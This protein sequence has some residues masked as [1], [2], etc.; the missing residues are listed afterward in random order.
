MLIMRDSKV[1]IEAKYQHTSFLN[2]G[3][4]QVNINTIVIALSC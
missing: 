2:V 4:I 1:M 3:E